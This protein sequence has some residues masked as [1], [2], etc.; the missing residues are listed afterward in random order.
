PPCGRTFVRNALV[1][2]FIPELL[3]CFCS[4]EKSRSSKT[5]SVEKPQDLPAEPGS[6]RRK[7]LRLSRQEVRAAVTPAMNRLCLQATGRSGV[8][9]R[10]QK[11]PLHFTP[12][13]L[14]D[15]IHLAQ[16][17]P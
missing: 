17:Q 9:L 10:A 4:V 12:S 5:P 1:L 8:P 3:T 11:L 13:P 15:L 7:Q 6:E 14:D 2:L 16:S